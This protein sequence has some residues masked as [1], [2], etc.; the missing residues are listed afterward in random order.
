MQFV[1]EFTEGRLQY[2]RERIIL[3]HYFM[4]LKTRVYQ[5][6]ICVLITITLTCPLYQMPT[7]YLRSNIFEL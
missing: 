5:E 6:T 4:C 3:K 1:F 7:Q 2:L